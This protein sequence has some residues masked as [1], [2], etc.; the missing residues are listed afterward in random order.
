[1]IHTHFFGGTHGSTLYFLY[2]KVLNQ[3]KN[4][5]GR[6]RIKQCVGRFSVRRAERVQFTYHDNI[7]NF[8]YTSYENVDIYDSGTI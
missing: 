4:H 2:Y 6:R 8:R 1:M 5:L 7:I 3:L